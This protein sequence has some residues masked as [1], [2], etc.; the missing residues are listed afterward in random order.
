MSYAILSEPLQTGSIEELYPD[1]SFPVTGPT[2]Q[3]LIE[4]NTVQIINTLPYDQSTQT[5]E[6]VTPYRIDNQVYS[7]IVRDLTPQEIQANKDAVKGQNKNQATSLL[8]ATDWT[9]VPSVSDVT[10]PVYLTN[11]TE[12]EDYRTQLRLIAVNPPETPVSTW[13]TK[14][15]ENWKT[16]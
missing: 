2:D 11:T 9:E 8:A 10:Q 3:W 7:V 12:F 6:Q 15:Q 13:P 1:T 4:H 14:P 16:N 5:L